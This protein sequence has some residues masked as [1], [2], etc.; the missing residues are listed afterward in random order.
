MS[1]ESEPETVWARPQRATRGPA[2]GRSRDELA[3][4][5]VELA[6]R[7]GLDAVSMRQ[8]AKALGTGQASLYRYIAGRDDLLD[9]MTDAVAREVALD[10]P[11]QG[12]P[13]DDLVALA[14]RTRAVQLR[15]PW[16]LDV[17]P[18]PLRLGPHGLDHLEYTLRAMEPVPLPGR[19]KL[20]IVGLTNALI[21]QL[22][23]AELQ[24]STGGFART[25][26]TGGGGSGHRASRGSAA[27]TGTSTAERHAADRRAAQAIYL[28][29]AAAE[30]DRPLIAAA[31]ADQPEAELAQDPE[32]LF[33]RTVRRMLTGLLGTGHH[34]GA[35]NAP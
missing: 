11:L 7:E 8:V 16:L 27:K 24:G 33:R 17:P 26:G 12:D 5:A 23:R 28:N 1:E 21:T 32:E 6:D 4:A 10:V 9:L 13:V 29:R 25:S 15:H 30:G 35:E 31:L 20:E 14:E 19:A 2:A 22:V 18:E 3:A 34:P